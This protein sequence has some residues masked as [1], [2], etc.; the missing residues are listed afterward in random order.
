MYTRTY[1]YMYTGLQYTP[2]LQDSAFPGACEIQTLDEDS[3]LLL[4]R[5]SPPFP[6]SSSPPPPPVL[7]S[8]PAAP[9]AAAS[10]AALQPAYV[11]GN[12]AVHFTTDT[13]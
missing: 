10:P 4:S 8:W 1:M 3:P 7:S 12:P 13:N 11:T 9:P 6:S 5:F 2:V